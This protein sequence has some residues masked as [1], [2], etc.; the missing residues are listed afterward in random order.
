[1][2]RYASHTDLVGGGRGRGDCQWKHSAGD[3]LY[4]LY[5]GHLNRC[6]FDDSQGHDSVF[7][8]NFVFKKIEPKLPVQKVYEA[9]FGPVQKIST[10]YKST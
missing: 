9:R 4:H 8:A 7:F 1:V 3:D 6:V 2:T 5:H 10:R